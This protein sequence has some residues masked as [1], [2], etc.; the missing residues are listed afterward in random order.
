[1]RRPS[2]LFINRV[3]PPV[4]GATGRVLR[5]LARSFAREGW[6]VTVI[7]TGPKALK[8][9]DGGVR[10]IRVK[11]AAKPT[12][13]F[14]Y[15]WIWLKMLV[16]ALR[17]PKTHLLVTMSDPPLLVL[18]GQ[19]IKKIKGTRHINWCH[20]LYPDLLPALG[21]WVPGFVMNFFRRLS[22][23]AMRDAD[24][25]IVI[26]RCMA[27]HL[28][29]DGI[30][31]RHMTMIP[32]WPD[33]ELARTGGESALEG[34]FMNGAAGNGFKP[35]EAQLKDGPKFRVLYAGNLG[36]AHP[37]DTILDAAEILNAGHP[38]IEFVFVGDGPR[39]DEIVQERSH[40][41]LD[42]IRLLPYQPSSL[43]RSMMESGDIHLISIREDVAGLLVPCKLY[44]AL[45]VQRPC[46]FIG[47]AQSEAAKVISDFKAGAVVAQGRAQDLAQQI[48]HFRMNGDDWFAAH[49]G[50]S[51]AANIFVPEESIE[52]W[53]Q[54]AW[55]VVEADMQVSHEVVGV[56]A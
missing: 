17:Q 41:R 32:N 50:A 35:H 13:V 48:L 19:I 23:A 8:E 51:A 10:V 26:G 28:T 43:L 6:Q 36:L 25:V 30:D 46:I 37:I 22:R 53:I 39:F 2:V 24:K 54:R 47:P 44:S 31:P 33:S 42:N 18:A 14:G 55:A 5:D 3:Y 1:M 38:E 20:D 4:R 11:G 21:V 16:T 29:Y 49:S 56:S 40:R 34:V 52:A 7:T 15:S 45:A 27:R 9:R 12:S